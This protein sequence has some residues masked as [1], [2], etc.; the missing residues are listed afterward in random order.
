MI[1]LK[2]GKN[3]FLIQKMEELE[4]TVIKRTYCSCREARF[5]SLMVA[6]SYL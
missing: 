4:G 5:G 2:R 6:R 3:G 1:I